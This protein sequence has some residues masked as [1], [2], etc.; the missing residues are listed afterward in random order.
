MHQP[1]QIALV[2][3]I[4]ADGEEAHGGHGLALWRGI[5][6]RQPVAITHMVA[7]GPL[8]AHGPISS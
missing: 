1:Q 6:K 7:D 4:E 3:V 8:T 2:H 5:T